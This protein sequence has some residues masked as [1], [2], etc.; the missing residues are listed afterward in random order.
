MGFLYP[1]KKTEELSDFEIMEDLLFTQNKI[2]ADVRSILAHLSEGRY[3]GAKAEHGIAHKV[4]DLRGKQLAGAFAEACLE[5]L[6]HPHVDESLKYID[7]AVVTA[8]VK[9]EHFIY[10]PYTD[11]VINPSMKLAK[12]NSFQLRDK[13]DQYNKAIMPYLDFFKKSNE[14]KTELLFG[15]H[16]KK[17]TERKPLYE[18]EYLGLGRKDIAAVTLATYGAMGE[19][20]VMN[21]ITKNMDLFGVDIGTYIKMGNKFGLGDMLDAHGVP[22]FELMRN[23]EVDSKEWHYYYTGFGNVLCVDKK[24]YPKAEEYIIKTLGKKWSCP[25]LY[26]KRFEVVEYAIKNTKRTEKK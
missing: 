19:P 7:D 14:E 23:G 21:I 10:P 16:E 13:Y 5:N 22:S 8:W 18:K 11:L 6:I 17:L 25:G 2:E 9:Y 20:G 1:N 15:N 3:A 4:T 26:G 24:Y 12:V